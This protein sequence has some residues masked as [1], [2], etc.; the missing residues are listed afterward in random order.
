MQ[1][2]QMISSG[3]MELGELVKSY[4]ETNEDQVF[5]MIWQKVRLFSI[6]ICNKYKSIPTE[7]KETI[8]MECL[9]NCFSSEKDRQ[10]LIKGESSLLT[11]YGTVLKNRLYDVWVK[12]MHS[13]NL[14]FVN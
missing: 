2:N 7:D 8:A 10:I 4:I 12:K 6:K 13:R 5:N 9:W 11:L 3:N 1:D 14:S